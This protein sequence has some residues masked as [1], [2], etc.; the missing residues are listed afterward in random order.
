[1]AITTK[2]VKNLRE[3]FLDEYVII[4]LKDLNVVLPSPDG[5]EMNITAMIDGYV[6]DID[7]NY[8]YLGLPED[9]TVLKAVA[10][11]S[12]HMIEVSAPISLMNVDFLPENDGDVH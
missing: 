5:Q 9:Q 3:C 12:A 1:M 8:V 11:E 10:H 2:S 7:E 4:Y 6:V